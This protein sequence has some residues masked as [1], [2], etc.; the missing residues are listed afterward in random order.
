MPL[1]LRPRDGLPS[2]VDLTG[3]TPD[4]L[5]GLDAEAI[6]RLTVRADTRP[7]P[8][9]ELFSIDGSVA[10]ARVECRGDFS[11]VDG[12]GA[13]MAAGRMVVD[14]SVGDRAGCAMS[15]GELVVAGRA[16]GWLAAAFAGG[17]VRVAG[18]C[19]DDAAAALP[20][21]PS[22]MNGG[23]VIINGHAGHRAGTR[24]RRG[25]VA[26]GGDC[27]P[28]AGFELQAGTLL[29]AGRLGAHPGLGMRR[30]S[31]VAAGSHPAPDP[32]FVRGATWTP[33]FLTLFIRRLAAS[34]YRPASGSPAGGPAPARA[35]EGRWQAAWVARRWTQWHGDTVAGARGEML[36]PEGG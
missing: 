27:G 9:G 31:I 23:L 15:G 34:G 22:G 10:D 24:M 36:T 11:R 5:A 19:G 12:V 6:A 4:R 14:G 1:V 25:I 2:T 30:G 8:L 17:M 16:G 13:G 29:V 35:E 7:I 3:I 28:A 32:T 18:D 26:I 21:K 33:P 20:G